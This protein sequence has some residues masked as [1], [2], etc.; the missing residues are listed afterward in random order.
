MFIFSN[1]ASLDKNIKNRKSGSTD[2]GILVN[3]FEIYIASTGRKFLDSNSI[4][5]DIMSK[6]ISSVGIS[7]LGLDEVSMQLFQNSL[8]LIKF[9]QE[10]SVEFLSLADLEKSDTYKEYSKH[11]SILQEILNGYVEYLEISGFEDMIT[12]PK[13]FLKS[14]FCLSDKAIAYL[15]EHSVFNIVYDGLISA[16]DEAVFVAASKYASVELIFKTD[17]YYLKTISRLQKHTETEIPLNSI[18]FLNLVSGELVSSEVSPLSNFQV[19]AESLTFPST[20]PVYIKEKVKSIQKK[21]DFSDSDV[22]VICLSDADY[23]MM[24]LTPDGFV[25]KQDSS[26][27]NTKMYK[28]LSAILKRIKEPDNKINNIV[29][30]RLINTGELDKNKLQDYVISQVDDLDIFDFSSKTLELFS[31]YS[32]NEYIELEKVLKLLS[33]Y[34][35]FLQNKTLSDFIELTLFE[36]SFSF[37]ENKKDGIQVLSLNDA[38]GVNLKLC[39]I[40]GAERGSF[41]SF[42]KK[43]LFLDSNIREA[44]SLPTQ[45]DRADLQKHYLINILGKAHEAGGQ[46]FFC[47]NTTTKK[48]PSI[49][50][51]EIGVHKVKQL[52]DKKIIAKFKAMNIEDKKIDFFASSKSV[53]VNVEKD[54]VLS[55][56][57]LK[58]YLTCKRKYYYQYLKSIKEQ[59]SEISFNNIDREFGNIV[60]N[61]ISEVMVVGYSPKSIDEMNNDLI[62][63]VK[64]KINNST[65]FDYSFEFWQKNL[66]S[67]VE[68]EFAKISTGEFYIE[69]VEESI[70]SEFAGVKIN[71]RPDRV[72]VKEDGSVVVVDYKTGKTP[73]LSVSGKGETDFQPEFMK[74]LIKYKLEIE[75]DSKIE[76]VYKN[77]KNAQETKAVTSIERDDAFISAIKSFV[78]DDGVYDMTTVKSN[79][80]FCPFSKICGR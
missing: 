5:A 65:E 41:P 66:S 56:T 6:V 78:A 79:C 15:N 72:D 76:F 1:K 58:T 32:I 52:N 47:L 4:R 25:F 57:K 14:G 30:N 73:D 36:L 55:A 27:Q 48:S 33:E 23:Q 20:Y 18:C 60:H 69:M 10:M 39:F 63:K 12:M 67:F 53:S 37:I 21:N 31:E 77:L 61:A 24:K 45:K 51:S 74:A 49:F 8:L 22:A 43:D 9:F 26:L 50:L 29:V 28:H 7:E 80:T 2:Q 35:L 17:E 42:A 38:R 54:R 19:S 59:T 16:F 64:E 11:I 13:Y 68:Q 62:N 44:V 71:G 75:S 40:L 70:T 46:T 3:E 34:H